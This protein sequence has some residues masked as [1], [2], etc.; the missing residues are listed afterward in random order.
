MKREEEIVI[1]EVITDFSQSPSNSSEAGDE[2]LNLELINSSLCFDEEKDDSSSDVVRLIPSI[3]D[4]AGDVGE[5]QKRDSRFLAYQEGKLFIPRT[6]IVVN[7]QSKRTA[8]HEVNGC[9][10]LNLDFNDEFCQFEDQKIIDED[11]LNQFSPNSINFIR[12]YLITHLT[13]ITSMGNVMS[14]A[15]YTRL[16]F[17]RGRVFNW[18]ILVN[19]Y[20]DELA[21]ELNSVHEYGLEFLLLNKD[22]FLIVKD[23]ESCYGKKLFVKRLQRGGV[24]SYSYGRRLFDRGKEFDVL[25]SGYSAYELTVELG[26][27]F[28]FLF[29]YLNLF[30]FWLK[31]VTVML[32]SSR[33]I[34]CCSKTVF[35]GQS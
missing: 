32:L 10:M 11:N 7:F 23:G 30:F 33:L 3:V 35:S 1:E 31:M 21:Y 18:S 26:F 4:G 16:L 24:T 8:A 28:D 14:S 13:Q 19:Q 34:K 5:I 29:K 27:C 22:A 9:N 20:T 6:E 15:Q 2:S 12:L 17:D 25:R